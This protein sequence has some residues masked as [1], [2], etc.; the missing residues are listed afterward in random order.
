LRQALGRGPHRASP[1]GLISDVEPDVSRGRHVAG[2][3]GNDVADPVVD[4]LVTLA[5]Q[6]VAHAARNGTPYSDVARN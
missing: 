1:S 2:A 4:K 5:Q 3:H 6:I